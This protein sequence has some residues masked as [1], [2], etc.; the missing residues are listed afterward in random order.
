MSKLK[1]GIGIFRLRFFVNPVTGVYPPYE[2]EGVLKHLSLLLLLFV[3]LL[4]L[5][6]DTL[7]VNLVDY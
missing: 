2:S 1:F 7:F 5:L 6:L 4:L 3:L